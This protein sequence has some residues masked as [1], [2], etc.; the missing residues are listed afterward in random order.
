MKL[1]IRDK[2]RLTLVGI[3][4]FAIGILASVGLVKLYNWDLISSIITCIVI[5]GVIAFLFF[6]FRW[7]RYLFAILFSVFW[8]FI[9]Y[10]F[11]ES[12]A[13]S[14]ANS[15]IVFIFFIVFYL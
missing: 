11:V 3:E 12:A 8:G 1:E 7:F 2:H 5:A 14:N 9:C 6:Q 4:V 10:T 13:D 15:L